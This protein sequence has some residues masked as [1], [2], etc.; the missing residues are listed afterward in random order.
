M[1]KG[2]NIEIDEK[3]LNSKTLAFVV[4]LSRDKGLVAVE[5]FERSL[6]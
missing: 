1:V 6:D 4:A 3:L 5:S 2:K